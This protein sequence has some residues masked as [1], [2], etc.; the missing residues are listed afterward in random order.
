[1]RAQL[2]SDSGVI[3]RAFQHW[4][5]SEL[6]SIIKQNIALVTSGIH[7]LPLFSE[8]ASVQLAL[9]GKFILV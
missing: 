9:L 8:C 6:Q 1:M 2:E 5:H 3:G 7:G 4:G